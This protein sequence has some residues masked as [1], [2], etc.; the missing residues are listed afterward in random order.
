MIAATPHA[1]LQHFHRWQHVGAGKS[2]WALSGGLAS[3]LLD[4][5][6]AYLP[7][8]Y[9]AGG[10]R[11]GATD[12]LTLEAQAK[13]DTLVTEGGLGMLIATPWGS[14]GV[15]GAVSHSDTQLGYAANVNWDLVNIRGLF[16]TLREARES[17]R[18]SAEYHSRQ[19]RSPGEYI[20]TVSGDLDPQSTYWLRLSGAYSVPVAWGT[21]ASLAARYQF[22]DP[23]AD[24]L[25]PSPVVGDRY[26]ADVTLSSPLGKALSASLTAGYSNEYYLRV[27]ESFKQDESSELRI[28]VR[29]FV[30]PDERRA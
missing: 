20:T 28:M 17:V 16:G 13:G 15:H 12:Q 27:P 18:L 26:G 25:S 2:E 23:Q 5:E 30:R 14:W 10:L 22:A 3:Y 9:L 21:T 7:G 4:G 29:L 24:T 11:Y 1:R 6:R 19:F 8:S